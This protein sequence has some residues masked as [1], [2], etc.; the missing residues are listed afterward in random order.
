MC[1]GECDCKKN[2]VSNIP[3]ILFL[4]FIFSGVV[5]LTL[6]PS[7]ATKEQIANCIIGEAVGEGY[8]GM[9]A[10]ALVYRNRYESGMPLLKG[11]VALKRKDLGDFIIE[12]GEIAG[13]LADMVVS[14]VFENKC[15]DFTFGATHYENVKQFGVPDW[16][17]SMD[18]TTI[19]GQHTFYKEK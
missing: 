18:I 19:I 14:E 17:D 13:N 4:V 2:K 12:Q 5:F 6:H 8:E 16:A 3:G 7:V 9:K 10:V 1:N 11:C 15:F